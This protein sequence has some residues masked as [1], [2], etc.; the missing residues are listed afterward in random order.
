MKAQH[1]LLETSNAELKSFISGLE[2]ELAQEK[3]VKQVCSCGSEIYPFDK[4]SAVF[5][6]FHMT[7]T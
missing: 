3:A 1:H 6:S 4:G 7:R 2:Q 5:S